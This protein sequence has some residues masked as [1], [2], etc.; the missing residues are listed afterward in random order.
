MP[1]YNNLA[2]ALYETGG[3]E[4]AEGLYREA[5]ARDPEYATAHYNLGMLLYL[6]G[7]VGEA[8]GHLRA[9]VRLLPDWQAAKE[10]LTAA[11]SAQAEL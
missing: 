5:I 4:E 11:E 2:R 6:S 8:T 1:L 3:R 7:D 9:A 10:A